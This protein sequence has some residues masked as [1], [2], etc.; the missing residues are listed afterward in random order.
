MTPND[1]EVR[2]NPGH[3]DHHEYGERHRAFPRDRR[4]DVPKAAKF[5]VKVQLSLNR[6]PRT[7]LIYNEDRTVLYQGEASEDVVQLM[8]NY[9]KEFFFAE[10]VPDPKSEDAQLIKLHE[11]AP[12]QDW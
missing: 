8:G 12:R 5:I 6:S 7:V 2:W 4:N 3:F 10:L 1:F 11:L 9:D